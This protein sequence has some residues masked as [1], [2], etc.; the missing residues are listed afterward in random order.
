MANYK[1]R[2]YQDVC[3]ECGKTF[4]ATTI[5]GAQNQAGRC[6]DSHFA[7]TDRDPRVVLDELKERGWE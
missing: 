5:I 1:G 4:T 7:D 6:Y 3:G 2:T